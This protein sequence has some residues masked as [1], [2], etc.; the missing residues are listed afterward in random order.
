MKTSAKTFW[1]SVRT[2]YWFVPTLMVLAVVGLWVLI[3]H[4]DQRIDYKLDGIWWLYTGGPEGARSLLSALIG[5]MI[6]V[7]GVVFSITIV[8][9]TLA[10]QQ[11]GPLLL[12][13]FIR[14]TGSQIVL[15][16]FVSTFAFS[17]LALRT[18][19][20]PGPENFVPHVSVTA[21]VTLGIASI[22]ILVYFIHHI[23]VFIQAPQ[24]IDVVY[25]EL[26]RAI[27]QVF[28][29]KLGMP[30]TARPEEEKDRETDAQFESR[31]GIV[32][33]YA[34]GYVKAIDG[35]LLLQTAK[36]HDLV[37]R[38]IRYPGDFVV[39]DSD[40]VFVLPADGVNEE[41][42]SKVN[43]AFIFGARRTATQDLNF[44][45]TQLV[46][47]AIRSLSPGINDPFTAITCIDHI[48]AAF[49][50]L[51]GRQLPSPYRHDQNGTLRV[52]AFP[53]TFARMVD[54][55]FD[56]IRYYGKT[57]P[58][59]LARLLWSISVAARFVGRDEDRKTLTRHAEIIRKSAFE[60]ITS[61]DDRL[62]VVEKY[63]QA[64]KALA[65]ACGINGFYE[66]KA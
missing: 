23:S 57:H 16:M 31:A 13:N 47:I 44:L 14:D 21:G 60:S 4:I 34:R 50:K 28:P 27:E 64:M 45:L 1:D 33:S 38:L 5:A 55:G 51:A 52:I 40:L 39:A 3:F 10:S 49:C 48:C 2:G 53:A 63:D 6:T 42:T 35:D 56:P 58:Q 66:G 9:L 61:E 41:V 15:G 18:V 29:E 8:V 46:E 25:A 43:A 30:A 17:L 65:G 37:V 26:D 12:R 22:G 32:R 59:V 36:E 19:R 11:F 20:G 54:A 62:D 24:L 7:A